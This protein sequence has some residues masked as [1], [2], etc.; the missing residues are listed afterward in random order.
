M[1]SAEFICVGAQKSGTTLL[2][3]VLK[4]H[5]Q[6][7]L[8]QIKETKFFQLDEKYN[9]GLNYYQSEFFKNPQ[10]S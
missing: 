7:F 3:D 5:E 10:S 8:P 4:Q 2:H 1:Q 9:H 6:I